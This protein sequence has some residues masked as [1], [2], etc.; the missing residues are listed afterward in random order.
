MA[1]AKSGFS[2]NTAGNI[3][4]N[5]AVIYRNVKIDPS[6]PEDGFT[7]D[8]LLGA[9]Q[10]GVEV[11]IQNGIRK[12]EADGSFSMD[13][14]GLNVYEN[15]KAEVTATMLAMTKEMITMAAHGT[16]DNDADVKGFTKIDGKAV[17]VDSDYMDNIAIVGIMNGSNRH[18]IFVFDNALVTSD[19]KIKM[20]DKSEGTVE[21]TAQANAT[22][23][24]VQAGELPWHIYFPDEVDNNVSVTGVTISSNVNT[25]AV[26]AE[27]TI[28]SKVS[29]D[30]A[31]N[32]AVTY[33]SSD[34]TIATVNEN[35]GIVSGVK[36]GNATIT[37]TTQ[38]GNKTAAVDITVT[39]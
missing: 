9:T 18:V 1:I 21:L 33:T 7:A 6:K 17:V 10:G 36:V 25:V 13:V 15:G 29:P 22:V 3:I 8:A 31:S 14:K 19:L 11:N 27:I 34:P 23:E 24:Q 32:P 5:A 35:T 26:G 4:I 30:N 12:I 37:A 38:D 16:V 20:E 2:D 39:A 28:T